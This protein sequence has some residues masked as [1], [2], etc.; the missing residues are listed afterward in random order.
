MKDFSVL[1]GGKAGDGINQAGMIIARILTRLGHYIYIYYDYPSLIRGGH[2]FSIIRMSENKI[3]AHTDK[4]DCLVALNQETFDLHKNRLNGNGIIIYDSDT[5]SIAKCPGDC[6]ALPLTAISKEE[7]ATPVMRNSI[8][9]GALCKALG[10]EEKIFTEVFN[11]HAG[12]GL[13]L[14][15][16]L[17]SRGYEMSKKV[18]EIK[19]S[20][21]KPLPILT[22]NEA[23]SL[24]LLKGGLDAYIAYP[25]TPVSSILHYLA[26]LQKDFDINV[27]HPENEISVILMAAGFAYAGKK[28]A[29]GS[30]GGGFCLMTEGVSLAGM[31]ELPI[32]IVMGQRPG[33]STG[34]PTYSSQTELHFILNAGQ[35]EFMRFVV[36]PGDA[37]DAY[38][39]SSFAL[40]AAWKYQTPSFI[41]IDKTLGEG[42]F[43]F[44]IESIDKLKGLEPVL[45]RLP[46]STRL[47]EPARQEDKQEPYKRYLNTRDGIS[48]LMFPPNK[49]AII[50]VNS[51]EH[52]ESGITTEESAPV[53]VMQEK[54]MRKGE[55]LA[56]ELDNYET[57]K[58]YGDKNS[59]TAILCWG[60]N[61]GVCVEIAEK[62]GLK[63]IQPVV[64]SPFPVS[65]FKKA[66]EGVKNII[67]VE[68]N[69]TGQLVRLINM[70]GFQVTNS[71]NKYDGRPFSIDELEGMIRK[72]LK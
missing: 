1:I 48:P 55:Y 29:V 28:A 72:L 70:Y 46:A 7:K 16:K 54:R 45:S 19:A 50:K 6:T 24:G 38:A 18:I 53:S 71:I 33:P 41:L 68:N 40:N 37:E 62:L 11:K 66:L 61:K 64:L 43:S 36:A 20:S 42:T 30:S 13:E 69:I 12:K 56:K 67:A 59:T 23:V 22:G 35:G 57:V 60:S 47:G 9:I 10:I 26:G 2:N 63:V 4:I 32:A 52:D 14:N 17:A 65:Q 44:D 49:E 58:N 27:I 3:A 51:Y 15:L 31:A 39:W 8:A 34:M 25:M 21:G 5:V